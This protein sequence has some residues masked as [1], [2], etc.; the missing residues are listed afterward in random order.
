MLLEQENKLSKDDKLSKFFPN[1]PK[2]DS[3]TIHQLLT[4]TSGIRDYHYFQNWEVL[5]QSELTPTDLINQVKIDPFRF[6]P[7]SSFRYSNT[8]YILLGLIIEKVSAEPFS[9]YIKHAILTSLNLRNTGI[10]TNTSQPSKLAK[11]YISTPESTTKV[12]Y[13]NYNQPF[14]SGNM[15]S[16]V[17]DLQRFTLAVINSELLP[18][19]ITKKVFENNGSYYGYGWG[20]RDFDGIKGYGHHGGMNG[21]WGSITYLPE[22]QTFICF[23][24]NDDNTP[25][26]TINRDLVKILKGDKVYP[27][28]AHEYRS[29][30]DSTLQAY[31]ATI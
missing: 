19:T 17:W 6:K 11:G 26:Y 4:H 18:K 23:L 1:F 31:V 8:G 5:S 27:P 14:S 10:I 24:T 15:H 13:I 16:T 20:L 12:D 7:G 3:V 29:I 28:I 22:S 2:A 9:E 21:Y 30:S 25:K